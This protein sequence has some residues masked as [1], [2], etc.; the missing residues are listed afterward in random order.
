[1]PREFLPA[2]RHGTALGVRPT[3]AVRE[4][5]AIMSG[6]E[7]KVVLA[8]Y[9][10]AL[11]N[12][13]PGLNYRSQP[14]DVARAVA[15]G[16]ERVVWT[17]KP[18]EAIAGNLARLPIE[19]MDGEEVVKD[20][21]V[22]RLLNDGKA[23]PLETGHQ[24]RKRLIAQ[25][26]LSKAGAFVEVQSSRAGTPLRFDLLPP[27]RTQIVPDAGE[28][29]VKGVNVTR[30]DG[31]VR[32]I[33]WE[34]VRWFREPHPLDPFSGI[35]PLEAMGLSI[36][37]DYFARLYN[38]SFLR[39]DGRPGGIL[40]I[41]GEMDTKDMDRVEARF[42]KG[43]VEAGKL[44]V[45]SGALS[46]V[47]TA[48]KPRDMAYQVLSKTAKDEQLAGWGVGESVLGNSSG[49]TFDNAEQELYNFWTVTCPPWMNVLET[50]F[51]SDV[52]DG[53]SLAHN[54][55]AVEV[56]Q[57][58]AA[59][60]RQEARDEVA[61]GLRS[62]YSYA[63]LA[64]MTNEIEE[65]PF[66][67]ALYMTSGKTPIPA[68]AADAEALGLVGPAGP[69]AGPTDPAAAAAGADPT[70]QPPADPT[71]AQ[72]PADQAG[73]NGGGGGAPQQPGAAPSGQ[74]GASRSPADAVAAATGALATKALPRI[75]SRARHGHPVLR[76]VRE[77]ETKSE[78]PARAGGVADLDQAVRERLEQ[79][80]AAVLTSLS[81]R[82]IERTVARLES[83]KA[84]KGTRHFTP[85]YER[86]TRVG[87]KALDAEKAVDE[88]RA[89][90]EAESNAEP[91]LTAAAV[92][93]AA[94][95]M[96]DLGQD[97][98]DEGTISLIVAGSV[99]A[100]LALVRRS[101]ARQA[102]LLRRL[103]G[104]L[105][106]SGS[107]IESIVDAVRARAESL[108]SWARGLSVQAATA[109]IEGARHDAAE[110]VD[111]RRTPDRTG[112]GGNGPDVTEPTRPV[113]PQPEPG[114]D[115]TPPQPEPPARP[116][117]EPGV[118]ATW[119][120][121]HDERVRHTHQEADGQ[122]CPVGE[123]FRVGEALLAYPGDPAGPPHETAQCRCYLRY[124]NAAGR[125]HKA[126]PGA[127]T[128][129]PRRA[130]GA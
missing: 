49:R 81:V 24:L 27:G 105:D 50:G 41:D 96:A 31:T 44:S 86:D 30:D 36:E 80:L 115:P 85:Q 79:D 104:D 22:A 123:R 62:I 106:S 18:V 1:M 12:A 78:E 84:R 6:A 66:T 117:P 121:Q 93:A 107:S 74:P 33:P 32:F 119:V 95:L 40:G 55:D 34:N 9:Y 21:P 42:G 37:L 108:A 130:M 110:V 129:N 15:E 14:W 52:E 3:G 51:D 26:L 59:K 20:H 128:R 122:T 83:P 28:T 101:A 16:Y 114:P 48:A 100:A 94:A 77:P 125:F 58:A 98:P 116:E 91:V 92:A 5:D 47:D 73:S 54:T 38:V 99:T 29:L 127:V 8:G 57:R 25:T 87:T 75:A 19:I 89:G 61:A 64:D 102:D 11:L 90:D 103:I 46:Y 118:T 72:P 13:M 68:K 97:E 17:F 88:Q 35:T 71:A 56:L 70:Q 120:T 69:S 109:T 113:T 2:L 43:P 124:R 45:I 82:W 10:Q 60:R 53:Y 112:D 111:V 67:R 39:N 23:N 65:T 7:A 63:Q 126:P 4:P 76:I